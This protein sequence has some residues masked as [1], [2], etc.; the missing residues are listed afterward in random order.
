[1]LYKD[2][3][4]D[5]WITL[6]KFGLFDEK[7]VNVLGFGEDPKQVWISAYHEGKLAIFKVN[8]EDGK[9]VSRELV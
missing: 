2:P 9:E 3:D 7:E 1:M 4:L 5:Q 6:W 8:I